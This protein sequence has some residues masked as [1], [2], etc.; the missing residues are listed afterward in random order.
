MER[1]DRLIQEYHH[2]PYFLKSKLP[3]PS[4]CEKCGVMFHNGVFDWVSTAPPDATKMVCP[5][6]RRI[7]D[8]FEGG[9]I[10]L[11]GLFLE[12]HKQEILNI[13]RNAENAQKTRRPLDR[14]IKIS[15]LQGKIEVTTTYEHLARRIGDA[16][17]SAY[18]GTLELQYSDGEKYVRVRWRRD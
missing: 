8:S 3:D 2:D 15:D 13:I 18:K 14:I 16:V 17:N 9:I 4:V 6:C 5:A 7:A 10:T 1:K 11:E 12:G